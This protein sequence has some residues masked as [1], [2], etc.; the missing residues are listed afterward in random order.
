MKS[1]V[2]YRQRS[3]GRTWSLARRAPRTFRGLPP[4]NRHI[5]RNPRRARVSDLRATWPDCN[6]YLM[7][8]LCVGKRH[9]HR[10]PT[11][12]VVV[13]FATFLSA[14]QQPVFVPP[15]DASLTVTPKRKSCK[16]GEKIEFTYR[17]R[18]TSNAEI[19]VPRTVWEVKCG[20]PPHVSASLEDSTG[21]HIGRESP[22]DDG[23]PPMGTFEPG[24]E[25]HVW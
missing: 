18:N 17:I 20:N 8:T 22:S 4:G 2:P 14:Q 19:F 21:K 11:F 25:I 6:N 9:I 5:I 15:N 13:L 24:F 10:P 23:R 12:A 7:I 16:I 3:A 1:V